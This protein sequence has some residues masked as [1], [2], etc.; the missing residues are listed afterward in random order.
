MSDGSSFFVGVTAGDWYGTEQGG[1]EDM[2]GVMLSSSGD[3]LWR[4][5]VRPDESQV[6]STGRGTGDER[7]IARAQLLRGASRDV[8]DTRVMQSLKQSMV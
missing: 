3:E 8:H 5:M 6:V 2:A 4:W 1:T 7:V